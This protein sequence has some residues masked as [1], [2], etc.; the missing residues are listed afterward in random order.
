LPQGGPEIAPLEPPPGLK[1]PAEELAENAQTYNK[2]A[3]RI[4]DSATTEV[5]RNSD[6]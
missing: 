6:W 5:L 3:F 1:K 2:Q 4:L